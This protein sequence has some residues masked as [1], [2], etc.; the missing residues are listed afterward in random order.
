MQQL[1]GYHCSLVI[2]SYCCIIIII[3]NNIMIDI[4]H[5]WGDFIVVVSVSRRSKY[6]KPYTNH[7]HSLPLLMGYNLGHALV[8]SKPYDAQSQNSMGFSKI[9]Q[10]KKAFITK[11]DKLRSNTRTHSAGGG[12]GDNQFLKMSSDFY[13]Y[14]VTHVNIHICH[15]INK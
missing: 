9:D 3:C 12:G 11:P 6:I 13:R 2:C 7:W 15:L 4:D 8:T 10:C 5:D 14:T 1:F